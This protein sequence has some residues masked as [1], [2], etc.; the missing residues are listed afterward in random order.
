MLFYYFCYYRRNTEGS[1]VSKFESSLF[2]DL[3]KESDTLSDDDTRNEIF[4]ADY[5]RSLRRITSCPNLTV[6][7]ITDVST[8]GYND[9]RSLHDLVVVSRCRTRCYKRASIGIDI[10]IHLVDTYDI[11]K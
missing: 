11:Y 5:V 7:I 6:Q 2:K 9:T 1:D 8:K 10:H 4:N 3:R